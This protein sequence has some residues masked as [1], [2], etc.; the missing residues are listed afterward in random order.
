MAR[1][2]LDP[3]VCRRVS[4][5]TKSWHCFSASSH[6]R[7]MSAALSEKPWWFASAMSRKKRDEEL[8]A[9]QADEEVELTLLLASATITKLDS[10]LELPAV[11]LDE[12]RLFVQLGD[13]EQDDCSC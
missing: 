9:A 1:H 10:S 6:C 11:H 5:W 12:G 8:H 7:S 13:M 3:L 4:S 2:N